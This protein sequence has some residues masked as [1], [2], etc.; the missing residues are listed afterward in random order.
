MR[1]YRQLL[2]LTKGK[3]VDRAFLFLPFRCIAVS[4][5]VANDILTEFIADNCALYEMQVLRAHDFEDSGRQ[6][7]D[8]LTAEQHPAIF[9]H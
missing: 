6:W 7:T 9:E 1:D 5:A 3:D 8:T 4:A 2:I